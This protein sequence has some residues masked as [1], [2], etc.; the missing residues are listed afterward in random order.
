MGLGRQRLWLCLAGLVVLPLGGIS[1][2]PAAASRV[3]V[4]SPQA[5]IR[6]YFAAEAAHRSQSASNLLAPSLRKAFS[7]APDRSEA[8]QNLVSV[9]NVHVLNG[10]PD[11]TDEYAGYTDL[12]K[13]GVEATFVYRRVIAAHSGPTVVFMTLG[14]KHGRGPWRVLLIGTGP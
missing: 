6:A 11:S 10:G 4:Q 5:T 1:A 12:W 7:D 2:S 3:H 9:S 8:A 13:F 14:K